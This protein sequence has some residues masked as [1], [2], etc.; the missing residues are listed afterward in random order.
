MDDSDS[1]SRD[2]ITGEVNKDKKVKTKYPS[3][4]N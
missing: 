2:E 1:S 3:L 4:I